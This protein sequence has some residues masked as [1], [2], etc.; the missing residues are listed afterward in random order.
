MAAAAEEEAEEQLDVAAAAAAPHLDEIGAA[1]NSANESIAQDS[2]EETHPR[3]LNTHARA[4]HHAHL[5]VPCPAGRSSQAE[6][7]EVP[8]AVEVAGCNIGDQAGHRWEI[9]I[10]GSRDS[11]WPKTAR[12]CASS[13][14]APLTEHE[15]AGAAA[16]VVL[17]SQ[18]AATRAAWHETLPQ[19]LL[20]VHGSGH[21]HMASSRF[22]SC[23][24]STAMRL[25]SSASS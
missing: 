24:S 8:V 3:H 23:W 7:A 19:P 17:P 18:A 10:K 15:P 22:G 12:A 25:R 21:G 11:S 6:A 4:S 13:E 16:R 1:E 5:V 2:G 14:L 20:R 9:V